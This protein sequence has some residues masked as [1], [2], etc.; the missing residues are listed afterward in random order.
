MKLTVLEVSIRLP[1]CMSLKEKRSRTRG[2]QRLREKDN[3]LF[4]ESGAQDVH[5]LAE[6]VFVAGASSEVTVDQI[7]DKLENQLPLLI[8]G[9]I[10]SI[11]RGDIGL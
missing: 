9:E 6:W 1:G 10:L 11:Q 3:L 2:L 7:M 8:D 4:F 5:S